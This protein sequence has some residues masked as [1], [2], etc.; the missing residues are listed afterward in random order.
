MIFFNSDY[1]KSVSFN[2][3]VGHFEGIDYN[4]IQLGKNF[5]FIERWPIR[6][7][8]SMRFEDLPTGAHNIAW[9]NRVVFDFFF[10]PEMWLKASLQF[11]DQDYRNISLIYGWDWSRKLHFYVAINNINETAEASNSIFSKVVYTF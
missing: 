3:A 11:K 5:K 9:L 1:W 6:Y 8:L 10:T 7:A 2:Y 4:E